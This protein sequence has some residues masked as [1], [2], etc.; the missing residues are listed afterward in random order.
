MTPHSYRY[1]FDR[2]VRF[3]EVRDT[4]QLALLAVESMYGRTAVRLSCSCDVD[5]PSNAIAIDTASE[6]GRRLNEVFAG[7]IS[8]EF[9]DDAV[10]IQWPEQ[11]TPHALVPAP[12]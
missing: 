10:V 2:V 7:Y 8:R 4:L 12:L 9:G 11:G 1:V 5:E 6:I 3:D